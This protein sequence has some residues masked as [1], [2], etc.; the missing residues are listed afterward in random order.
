MSYDYQRK[1]RQQRDFIVVIIG[2]AIGICV[3]A[4]GVVD[5]VGWREGLVTLGAGFL[6][7]I[8]IWGFLFVAAVVLILG[9]YL[10]QHLAPKLPIDPKQQATS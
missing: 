4:A 10:W 6:F 3:A 2:I 7:L 1:V 9:V 5:F 8:G